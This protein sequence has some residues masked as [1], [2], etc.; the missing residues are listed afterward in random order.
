M[1]TFPTCLSEQPE[2]A[3]CKKAAKKRH[4]PNEHPTELDEG[5]LRLSH[6]NFYLIDVSLY[7][8]TM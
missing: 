3:E 1:F 4:T 2:H 8:C 7:F 6:C 5:V